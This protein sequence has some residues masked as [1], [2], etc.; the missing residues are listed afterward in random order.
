MWPNAIA[1]EAARIRV[2][3][4]LASAVDALIAVVP[5]TITGSKPG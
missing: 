3:R 1:G 5:S 4:V 2:I